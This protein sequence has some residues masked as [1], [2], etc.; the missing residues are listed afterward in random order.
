LGKAGYIQQNDSNYVFVPEQ[1]QKNQLI[2]LQ[3]N[4]G[5]SNVMEIKDCLYGQISE[6]N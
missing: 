5:S 4:C 6:V 1:G 2:Q 3:E